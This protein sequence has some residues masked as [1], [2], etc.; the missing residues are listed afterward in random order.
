MYNAHQPSDAELPSTRQLI[1][2]TMLA[3]LAA[4]VI[5]VTTVLPAEYA[6]DPTG[7]GRILGLTQMGEV[8]IHAQMAA[9]SQASSVAPVPA[10]TP[11]GKSGEISVI[12]MPG[13]GAEVKVEMR[14]GKRVSYRWSANGGVVNYDTH[15]EPYNASR[16]FSHSYQKGRGTP[17]DE[18]VLEA[19][20]DGHHG[21]YWEN[22]TKKV[23]K[24]TLWVKGDYIKLKRL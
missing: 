22:R 2:S 5:L 13:E 15:G 11:P 6:I 19:A 3:L 23:L 24:V 16:Y 18:G 1:R 9:N 21:W 10:M 14:K 8:K 7:I 12:L 20:F 4:I 17:G